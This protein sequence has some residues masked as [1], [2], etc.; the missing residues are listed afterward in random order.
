[1]TNEMEINAHNILLAFTELLLA[2]WKDWKAVGISG[3]VF[4]T[5]LLLTVDYTKRVVNKLITSNEKFAN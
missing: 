3:S 5:E 4:T 2:G 1:M